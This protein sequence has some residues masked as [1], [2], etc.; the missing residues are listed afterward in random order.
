MNLIKLKLLLVF[1]FCFFTLEFS[2][3]APKNFKLNYAINQQTGALKSISLMNCNRGM[4][5]ILS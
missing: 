5:W 3:S 1:A 4:N 2:F